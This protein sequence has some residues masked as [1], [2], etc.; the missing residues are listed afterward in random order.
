MASERQIAA[1]RCNARSSTGPRTKAG[2]KRAS[3]NALRHG[4]SSQGLRNIAAAQVDEL[5]RQIAGDS[6]NAIV[7]ELARCA[8]A[9]ERDLDR[10]RQ[11]RAAWIA[12]VSSLGIL[13]APKPLSWRDEL[14][15]IMGEEI[16]A[17][18]DPLPAMPAA[19]AERTAEAVRRILPE[20][21][22][23]DRYERRA[24]AR[25]DKAIRKISEHRKE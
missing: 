1:N 21:L 9:A 5:A 18:T 10:V 23:I 8:A 15:W 17:T 19:D 4:L 25:R 11:V 24:A 7:L 22:R 16:T 13:E 14:R 12:K 6:N 20:L 3:H 2:K